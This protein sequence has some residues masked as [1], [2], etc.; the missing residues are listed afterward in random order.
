MGVEFVKG[1]SQSFVTEEWIDKL[2]QIGDAQPFSVL[3]DKYYS[4]DEA[5]A[6]FG[7]KK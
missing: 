4:E 7:K 3:E 1:L 2:R 5:K 6:A